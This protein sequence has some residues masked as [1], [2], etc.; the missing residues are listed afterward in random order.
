MAIGDLDGDGKLDIAAI[1][2]DDSVIHIY[3][4]TSSN[5]N[6]RFDYQSIEVAA[7]TKGMSQIKIGDI[8]GDGKL[9]IVVSYY[10]NNCVSIFR[11]TGSNDSISFANSEDLFA[12]SYSLDIEIGDINGDGKQDIAVGNIDANILSLFINKSFQGCF[13]FEQR[14]DIVVDTNMYTNVISFKIGDLN[15]DGKQDIS[16]L[17]DVNNKAQLSILENIGSADTVYFASKLCLVTNV[18]TYY[19]NSSIH[20]YDINGD[21]KLDLLFNEYLAFTNISKNGK[22]EFAAPVSLGT[23]H[24]G[25]ADFVIGDLDGDNRPEMADVD[26]SNDH[27]LIS[28]NVIYSNANLINLTTSRGALYPWFSSGY[29]YPTKYYLKVNDSA[30]F[31]KVTPYLFDTSAQAQL[32]INSGTYNTI[33]SGQESSELIFD[34][35]DTNLIEIMITTIDSTNKVYSIAVTRGQESAV[36]ETNSTTFSYLKFK[37]NPFNNQIELNYVSET[38]SEMKLLVTDAMG[39]EILNKTLSSALG[40]NTFSLVEMNTLKAGVYF[41]YLQSDDS[42]SKAI[43]LIKE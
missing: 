5:G 43:K 31:I 12:I 6:I 15:E 33:L 40:E 28:Q 41:A 13:Y 4:N 11:N 36:E 26:G 19:F 23:G 42:Y 7:F 21:G 2:I 17:S 16:F 10:Y 18:P 20:I 25:T 1:D 35:R 29:L 37:P 24:G 30:K 34:K 32:R 22:I 14:F 39:R 27:I 9:D 38:K 8:D 3:R